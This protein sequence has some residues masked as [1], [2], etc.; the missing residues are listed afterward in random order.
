MRVGNTTI[1][2]VYLYPTAIMLLLV[3]VSSFILGIFPY[4]VLVAVLVCVVTE[5]LFNRFFSHKNW[6]HISLS[7]VITG[8]IIGSIVP[9]NPPLPLVAVAGIVAIASKFVLKWKHVQ[10]FNPAAIGVLFAI[11][12]FASSDVWWAE[13]TYSIYGIAV[14]LAPLLILASWQARRLPA[15]FAFV[16]GSLML[17]FVGTGFPGAFSLASI[18]AVMFSVNYI[19]AFLMLADPK[20]S[21]QHTAHQVI[22]GLGVAMLIYLVSSYHISYPIQVGLLAGNLLFAFYRVALR[23]MRVWL[24]PIATAAATA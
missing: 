7:A 18:D 19:L 12:V 21:P 11:A 24:H 3:A 6:K 1:S 8:L 22:Y 15:S 2:T 17:G 9:Q 16:A 23:K 20:T 4:G 14:S 13:T 5:I 10:I